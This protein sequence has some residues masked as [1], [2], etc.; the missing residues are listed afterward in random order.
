M[1]VAAGGSVGGGASV[2]GGGGET[3]VVA[4]ETA[5][6]AGAVVPEL[7]VESL[8]LDG[9]TQPSEYCPRCHVEKAG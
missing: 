2:G 1:A 6:V 9:V 3:W 4:G 8:V 5:V 7:D